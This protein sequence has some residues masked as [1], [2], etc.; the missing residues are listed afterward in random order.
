M[1]QPNRAQWRIIWMVAVLLILA[2]PPREGGSLALK[3][4]R[5]LADPQNTL[6]AM[7]NPLPMG[8]GDDGDAVAEHDRQLQEYFEFADA[9]AMNRLRLRMKNAEEPLSPGTER[10]LLTG[11]TVLAALLVWKLNG[12]PARQ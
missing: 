11:V 3:A 9:S 10:Q 1:W 8:L 12:R 2:W 7:P 5:S 4:V 6:P